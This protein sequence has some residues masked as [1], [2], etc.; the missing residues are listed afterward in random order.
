MTK[1]TGSY[2][3]RKSAPGAFLYYLLPPVLI[4]L[5]ILPANGQDK[6]NLTLAYSW[7]NFV[8]ER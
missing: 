1:R 8:C 7:C 4:H 3:L 2:Y 5:G 6:L